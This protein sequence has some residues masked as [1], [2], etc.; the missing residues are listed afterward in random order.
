[1]SSFLDRLFRRREPARVSIYDH[2]RSHL[3]VQGPGLTPGGETLPDEPDQ[4]G[5]V[6]WAPGAYDGVGTH[7]MGQSSDPVVVTEIAHLIQEAGNGGDG[8]GVLERRLREIEPISFV[9]PLM[10]TVATS[11][12]DTR[13]LMAVG[14]RLAK[15]SSSRNSVKV[16]IVLMGMLRRSNR[17]VFMTLGRHDEFTL[18]SAVALANTEEEPEQALWHLAQLVQGWGR[19]H[20][21][22]RLKDTTRPDIRDWILRS[23]FRN[24]VMNEYLA[25]I[26]AT[27]GGLLRAL[28]VERPDEELLNAACDIISS[29]IVGGPA[30]NID[31]YEDAPRAVELLVDHLR[32]DASS[33]GHFLAVDQIE[34]FLADDD[35]K[36]AS[37]EE[38]GWPRGLREPLRT[39]CGEIK[40]R[41][42][43]AERALTA[44]RADDEHTFYEGD[45]VAR[46]LGIDTIDVHLE[47]L[48]ADPTRPGRYTV[49]EIVDEEQ[50][51]RVLTLAEES[52][53]LSEIG[54]GPSDEL[55]LGPGF[56]SHMALGFVVQGLRRFPGKGW[57]LIAVALRSPVVSN[58][59]TALSALEAW[60]RSVW[61]TEAAEDLKK[62]AE[63]EPD[64]AV[65]ERMERILL[66]ESGSASTSALP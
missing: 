48:A 17:D 42:E 3:P 31:D 47:R 52:L 26:A 46:V 58:R 20:A 51:D 37:R 53:P 57:P 23:G 9:D 22:E 27:T 11:R 10:R 39:Q 44:V 66:R 5:P 45:R 60:D 34:R 18:Y 40:S 59:N 14:K 55:G 29:L 19:V 54:S 2:I 38:R 49:M 63:H 24:Q 61:P 15:T 7:H 62:L 16:G 41:P 1:M 56:Q 64:A 28:E 33:L 4:E 21:V 6:R 32:R 13:R 25:Y 12:P 8:F 30:E 65:R 50:L 43:W 36:W 35:E